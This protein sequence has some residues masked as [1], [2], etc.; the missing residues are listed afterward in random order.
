VS[1][2]ALSRRS[3]GQTGTTRGVVG[4]VRI[5]GAM[6]SARAPGSCFSFRRAGTDV[7]SCC[8]AAPQRQVIPTDPAPGLLLPC[9]AQPEEERLAARPLLA[10]RR[11]LCYRQLH[12]AV[13]LAGTVALAACRTVHRLAGLRTL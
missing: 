9:R 5:L 1:L 6:A 7:V 10:A 11:G 13:A 12:S 3:T 4:W 8:V 2:Q